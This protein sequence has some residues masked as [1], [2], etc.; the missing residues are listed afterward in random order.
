MLRYG[1]VVLT[2]RLVDSGPSNGDAV[3]A[4]LT[5]MLIFVNE[6]GRW[7]LARPDRAFS[8][9]DALWKKEE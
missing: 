6:L 2:N 5:T 8:H 3:G 4:F 9:D 1:Q 7:E